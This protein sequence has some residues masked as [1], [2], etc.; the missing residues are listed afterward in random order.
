MALPSSNNAASPMAEA[1]LKALLSINNA[2]GPKTEVPN[3]LPN[4]GLLGSEALEV[5]PPPELHGNSSNGN[6]MPNILAQGMLM[7]ALTQSQQ[8]PAIHPPCSIQAVDAGVTTGHLAMFMGA[9]SGEWPKL[10]NKLLGG[11]EEFERKWNAKI[12]L[13][14]G[15]SGGTR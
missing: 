13:L 1:P 7:E 14:K 3:A 6:M 8:V 2:S 12:K 15:V 11:W 10:Q 9:R 4:I 5:K